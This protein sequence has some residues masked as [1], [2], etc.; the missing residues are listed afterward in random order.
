[1]TWYR[2]HAAADRLIRSF[3][4]HPEGIVCAHRQWPYDRWYRG[5]NDGFAA[6]TQHA[7]DKRDP[8][9]PWPKLDTAQDPQP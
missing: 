8:F 4:R 6:A 9:Y 3:C 5:Y 2:V 1:M 7:E